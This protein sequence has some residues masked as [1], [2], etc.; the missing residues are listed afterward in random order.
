MSKFFA[1]RIE[2]SLYVEIEAE[3]SD[4]AVD[5]ALEKWEKNTPEEEI[6]VE[7]KYE[8]NEEED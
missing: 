5:K 1:I 6:F 7:G 4:E 8:D 3:N 2:K